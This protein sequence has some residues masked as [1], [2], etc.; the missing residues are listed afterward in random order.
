VT[1]VNLSKQQL[2]AAIQE[3]DSLL[4]MLHMTVGNFGWGT[5]YVNDIAGDATGTAAHALGRFMTTGAV[6]KVLHAVKAICATQQQRRRQ[7]R[8]Q[9]QQQQH[10]D[11]FV[12]CFAQIAC[13]TLLTAI[14]CCT[15]V[16]YRY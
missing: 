1:W 11:S 16:P 2:Q 4:T 12:A 7:Q 8:Q 10:A 5:E 9:Q 6:G 13:Y 15:S 3:M 14:H